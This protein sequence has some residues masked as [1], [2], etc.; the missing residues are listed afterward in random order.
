M[1]QRLRQLEPK[2]TKV[3]STEPP[4]CVLSSFIHWKNYTQERGDPS[5]ILVFTEGKQCTLHTV[6]FWLVLL[7]ENVL[8][9]DY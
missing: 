7:L 6:G 2:A 9:L 1:L 5:N 8:T 4:V 3:L